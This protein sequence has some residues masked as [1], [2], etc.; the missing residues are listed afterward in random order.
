[1]ACKPRNRL[2]ATKVDRIAVVDRPCVPDAQILLFKRHNV[3]DDYQ[4]TIEKATQA[5]QRGSV[6]FPSDSSRVNDDKDHFPINDAGQARNALARVA[7][8]SS[9]P[10][11]FEGTLAELQTAVRNA[12]SEKFPSIDVSKESKDNKK[13][14]KSE[15][16]F[17]REFGLRSAMLATELL[18]E[19]FWRTLYYQDDQEPLDV[20]L[21]K[22]EWKTLVDAFRIAVG[23]A[24]KRVVGAEMSEEKK[25]KTDAQKQEPTPEE[26]VA[27]F[28]RGLNA[29]MISNA[30]DYLRNSVAYYIM[31]ATDLPNGEALITKVIDI[32]ENYLMAHGE[33]IIT[34]GLND[35]ST[36]EKVGRAISS[37]RLSKLRQALEVLSQV[38]TEAEGT[39]ENEKKEATNMNIEEV[40]KAL[41]ASPLLK[42][43][44]DRLLAIENALK[45]H[46]LVMTAE[47][48]SALEKATVEKAEAEK[49]E[50][51]KR[52]KE[53]T[54][55]AELLKKEKEADKARIEKIEKSLEATTKIVVELG[56]KMGVKTSL[57][58]EGEGAG[59]EGATGNDPFTKALKGEKK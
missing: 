18:Q 10:P 57:V 24:V 52:Q 39:E 35:P 16:S 49:I 11:W 50:T 4:E 54:E 26:V 23:E 40:L 28:E 22:A 41:E 32:F 21:V 12:V 58:V 37:A 51:E 25:E 29:S 30:F 3:A 36:T 7:Q 31:T 48:K 33:A 47:E 5:Q 14:F 20:N 27:Q 19:G 53:A 15:Y 38:I 46:K 55:Q 9:K 44:A 56:K 13:I 6:V 42:G 2:K 1:M 45:E 8:Y 59:E 43:L 17:D 34:K